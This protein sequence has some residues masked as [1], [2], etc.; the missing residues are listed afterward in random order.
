[1]QLGVILNRV[2]RM[3]DNPLFHFVAEHQNE[4]DKLYFILPLEDLSD[5]AV[6]K[7]D[8]YYKVVKGFVSALDK[9]DIHPYIVTYERLGELVD[10]LTLSHVLVGK[11][12]MSYHKEIYDYPHIKQAFEKH[13][14]KVIGQRVNH[15]F[16]PT[17]TFNKKQQPYKVFTS[18]YKENRQYLVHT[19]QKSYQFKQLSQSAE[20]GFNQ[21]ELRL[22]NNED[23]E[24]SA[25]KAWHRFL[26]EDI[27]YYK[28]LADDVS[29]DFV[30]GLG[31][32]LAYGLLDIRE[33]INDLLEGY[34]IH[35]TS[36]ESFIR[37]V[38]FREFYYVL[39]SQHPET[40]TKSFYEKY[41]NMQWSYNKS[42]FEA[43][44]KEKPATQLLM[45]Q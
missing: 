22:D 16:Q 2:F 4:I 23:M 24:K 33:V 38:M 6:V 5:A 35:E 11:D 14:I 30:S 41:R 36:Y 21:S 9:Y 20:K 26:D 10:T 39:M 15:Y 45:L 34:D 32:Y 43:W 27:S 44:K 7:R 25:R 8:Y 19:P 37:E 12:I 13:Q 17:K 3:K 40:A 1:M 29:Q 28:Q 31:K 18:F 42:H